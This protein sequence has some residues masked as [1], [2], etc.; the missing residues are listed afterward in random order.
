MNCCVVILGVAVLVILMMTRVLRQRS[1]HFAD[2]YGQGMYGE[3]DA[4]II[5]DVLMNPALNDKLIRAS[6]LFKSAWD[7]FPTDKKFCVMYRGPQQ[8]DENCCWWGNYGK[9]L[10]NECLTCYDKD[11]PG[12]AASNCPR[13]GTLYRRCRGCTYD[14]G[15][16]SCWCLND[17]ASSAWVTRDAK[18]LKSIELGNGEFACIDNSKYN[19]ECKKT[20]DNSIACVDKS[21]GGMRSNRT[22]CR[23]N[24]G[25]ADVLR[26][27]A[28]INHRVMHSPATPMLKPA[29]IAEN[30][31]QRKVGQ[32]T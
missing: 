21:N 18:F 7:F 32:R 30:H 8:T 20:G 11:K 2:L 15:K 9:L 25:T 6:T 3:T 26:L 16:L 22:Q 27:T 24:A 19:L 4:A 23:A 5:F 17:L 10:K 14:D 29:S 31:M 1:E 28:N 13:R 12:Q